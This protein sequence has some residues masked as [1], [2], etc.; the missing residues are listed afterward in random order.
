MFQQCIE[1][2]VGVE[3]KGVECVLQW[4]S[5]RSATSGIPLLPLWQCTVQS[6]IEV[7]GITGT[8]RFGMPCPV[9]HNC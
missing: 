2:D 4:R 7:G 6:G 1:C 8:L 3:L 9:S 5:D